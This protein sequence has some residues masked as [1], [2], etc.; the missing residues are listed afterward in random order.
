MAQVMKASRAE[1]APSPAAPSTNPTVTPIT[2]PT[3]PTGKPPAPRRGRI[4]PVRFIVIGLL[5]LAALAFGGHQVYMRLTHVSE[6]DAR[7]TADVVTMSS[8]AEGWVTD[9]PALEGDRVEA[10]QVVARIDD[11]TAKLRVDALQAQIEAIQAERTRLRAERRQAE[12]AVAAKSRTRQS[13]VRATEAARAALDSDILLAQQELGRAR[14]LAQRGIITDRQLETAQANVT[15]LESTRRK[16]DAERLQAEGS[17]GE[18]VAERDRLDVIDGQVAALAPAEANLQAQLAQLKIEIGD[19]TIKSPVPAVIDRVFVEPGE[20]VAAGQRIL[21]LHDPNEV[22]VEANIKETQLRK[23][24]L[25]QPVAITVDAFPDEKFVGKV[26]RVGSTT[27]A[28]FALLPTPN[29]SGNFTKITQRVPV[30]VVFTE[31]PR[32]VS[33]GMMVEVDIDIR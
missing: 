32:P 14:N 26:A 21:I 29:P 11:R 2:P 27:T 20:Y 25:G 31:M 17:L 7:V 19:R 3:T 22:W 24:K 1:A 13:G 9:L 33:P 28:R 5:L 12:N 6:S 16:L 8:R 10:G 23:L 18:A 4:R 30:K 15:R